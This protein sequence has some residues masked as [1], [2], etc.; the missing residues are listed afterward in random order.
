[1]RK[2]FKYCVSQQSLQMFFCTDFAFNQFNTH[3][4][5]KQ[6]A[7][8]LPNLTSLNKEHEFSFLNKLHY[9]FPNFT[10]KTLDKAPPFDNVQSYVIFFHFV[11]FIVI[12]F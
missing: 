8:S 1:M 11:G 5:I 12:P 7:P 3:Y 2:N 6:Y 9:L 10:S 4:S